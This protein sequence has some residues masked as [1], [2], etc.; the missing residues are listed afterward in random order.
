MKKTTLFIF[1]LLFLFA[2]K[3]EAQEIDAL[4]ITSTYVT[5]GET[6]YTDY[7][8]WYSVYTDRSFFKDENGGLHT[9]FLSN[10]KLYYCYSSD[11]TTWSSEQIMSTYSGDFIM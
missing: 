4:N 3:V 11:G 1:V 9:V 2:H 7:F 5:V 6:W 10:Y 8:T